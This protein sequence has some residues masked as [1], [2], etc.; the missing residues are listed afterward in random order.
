MQRCF[1]QETEL[2]TVTSPGYMRG[3]IEDRNSR[4]IFVYNRE[5]KMTAQ[6]TLEIDLKGVF[7][8]DSD[9]SSTVATCYWPSIY[10]LK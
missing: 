7:F 8:F 2:W 9:R 3:K 1:S 4:N 6:T 10:S 5:I